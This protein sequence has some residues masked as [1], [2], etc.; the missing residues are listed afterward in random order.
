MARKSGGPSERHR[1]IMRFLTDFQS[2]NGYSPSIRE[3]GENIGVS[4][5]S[6][7]DYYLKQLEDWSYIERDSHVSRSI[8][9]LKP[10]SGGVMGK[11]KG[12][13]R[14]V[15]TAVNDIF[16]IP[17]AG[18]IV[19]SAPIPVPASDLS[20]FDPESTVEIARSML[21]SKEST[22]DLFALE[23][24]GDSMIDAMIS[25]GDIVIMKRAQQASNGEMVAVWLDDSDETTLKYF[26]K[27]NKR[28]RLQPANPTMSPIYIDNLERLRIMGKVVMVIRQVDNAVM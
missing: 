7:V 8:R 14:E 20:Y 5:T 6:L 17:L 1:K 11:V 4:S 28:V 22:E 26:Y 9:I 24:D 23:V 27:E 12:A 2:D 18:R 15:S 25:D 13:V 10:L 19:A 21:P 3:I 16:S